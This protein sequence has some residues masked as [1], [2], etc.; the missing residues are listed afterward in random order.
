MSPKGS[1]CPSMSLL[2]V[3]RQVAHFDENGSDCVLTV[4]W[5][6]AVGPAAAATTVKKWWVVAVV[7]TLASGRP[8]HA[9]Q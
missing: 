6:Q 5:G 3:C 9:G 7:I 2:D 8:G 4:Q 1:L